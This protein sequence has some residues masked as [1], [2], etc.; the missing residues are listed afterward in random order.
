MFFHI[1]LSHR[2]HVHNKQQTPKK[3]YSPKEWKTHSCVGYEWI[4]EKHH[5]QSL[6][7]KGTSSECTSKFQNKNKHLLSQLIQEQTSKASQEEKR[8]LF[9]HANQE[10]FWEK[11]EFAIKALEG[12][13]GDLSL[14]LVSLTDP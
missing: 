10:L 9:M 12:D 4:P 6:E 8:K 14:V 3:G 11:N 13:P 7:R 5:T 2:C 1:P